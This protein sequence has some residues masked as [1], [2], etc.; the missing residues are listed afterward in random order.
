MLSK[1][2]TANNLEENPTRQHNASTT[3]VI[4]DVIALGLM[5]LP[6]VLVSDIVWQALDI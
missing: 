4:S 1:R 6:A 2:M 3:T 5:S